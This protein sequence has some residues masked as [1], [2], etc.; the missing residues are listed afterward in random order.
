M[1]FQQGLSAEGL[2][3]RMFWFVFI[4]VAA[5]GVLWIIELSKIHVSKS[6]FLTQAEDYRRCIG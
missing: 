3:S 1:P 2:L 5:Q 6:E 4:L